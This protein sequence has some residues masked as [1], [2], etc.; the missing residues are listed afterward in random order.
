MLVVLEENILA[1]TLN[2]ES[3]DLSNNKLQSFSLKS[4]NNFR[5]LLTL[6]LAYNSLVVMDEKWQTGYP[7]LRFL[8]I[9]HNNI[10]PILERQN[11]Q[12][13]NSYHGMV[14]TL[15][16]SYNKI[17]RVNIDKDSEVVES[18]EDHSVYLY[19]E[20]NPIKCDCSATD[21]SCFV[22]SSFTVIV[23]M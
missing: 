6:N 15:D 17:E 18:Q 2:L 10:G 5:R 1:K 3:L 21:L 23:G 12:Y 8:N 16:L 13:L 4:D 7:T 9:S 22:H 20:G 11:I 19:L 14:R